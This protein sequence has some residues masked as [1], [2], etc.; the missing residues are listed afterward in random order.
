MIDKVRAELFKNA[1]LFTVG[2]FGYMAI[3]ICFRGYTYT[4]M[5]LCGGIAIILLDK[6]NS[7]IS[8]DIDFLLQGAIGGVLITIMELIIG[9]LYKSLSLEPMWDYSNIPFNIDGVICLPFTLAWVML[10]MVAIILA[11]FI[12]YYIFNEKPIPYYKIFGKTVF[13]FKNKDNFH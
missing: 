12:N 6:V 13:K 2:F 1:V 3:E 8:W 5:G 9:E 7:R 4:S 11:D 10:S